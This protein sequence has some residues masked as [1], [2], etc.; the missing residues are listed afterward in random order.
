[1]NA[2]RALRDRL[3]PRYDIDSLD[4]R[5]DALIERLTR[6][7]GAA[8]SRYFACEV[9]GLERIPA[10]AALY[11][12]N[13]NGAMLSIDTFLFGFAVHRERGIAD[14]PYGL[15]HEVAISLPGIN[16]TLSRLGA[17]RASHDNAHRLFARG[18]KVLVYPG[19]DYE[20]LRPFRRRDEVDFGGRKGYVAL[21][22]A[23]GVPIVP[24]VAA[25]AHETIVIL[26]DLRWLARAL[27]LDR[28][29]RIKVWPLM[30]SVP[31]G[32]TLGPSPPYIPLP[33]RILIE[34]LEPVR[35]ERSGPDAAADTEYVARCAA[36][37]EGRL[38]E[39]LTRL[40]K[41]RRETGSSVLDRA[42]RALRRGARGEGA[43]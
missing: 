31:W 29:L 6:I 25:G 40:C 8:L 17:V 41:E 35:F 24:I 36:E 26:D 11:V 28:L 2:V 3:A 20:A 38:Q 37:V 13:H 34:V 10:G 1:M 32:L 5:D 30:L 12:G 42:D 23:A 22:L 7:A 9:R 33:T 39:A 27:R 15:G 19:G 4:N 43:R 16:G 18:A 21:A 14:V